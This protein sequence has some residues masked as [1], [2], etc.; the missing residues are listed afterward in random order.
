MSTPSR[1]ESVTHRQPLWQRLLPRVGAVAAGFTALCC[2]GISA[3]LSLASSVGATFLTRDSS[4][5]PLLAITL[6]VTALGSALTYWRHRH[7][8]PL[9]L[10]VLAGAWVYLFTFVVETSSHA[11]MH[12]NMGHVHE[13]GAHLTHAGLTGG[14]RMLV[15][16][17]LAVLVAAQVWDVLRVRTAHHR[18]AQ[19]PRPAVGTS[20][21]SR[22]N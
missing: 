6:V 9:L 8:G 21:G 22:G 7:P 3:A 5:K 18:V 20:G 15:W 17:G 13:H 11:P 10:T 14:R 2:L 16:L 4:V 12:D 19:S 1:I